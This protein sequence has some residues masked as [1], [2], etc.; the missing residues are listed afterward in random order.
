LIKDNS[1]KQLENDRIMKLLEENKGKYSI[2][3]EIHS[4]KQRIIMLEEIIK[5][6]DQEI[7]KK[8]NQFQVE[9]H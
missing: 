8:T 6:K 9:L 3:E 5:L 7:E 1:K 4:Y 2:V